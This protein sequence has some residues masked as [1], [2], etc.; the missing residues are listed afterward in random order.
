MAWTLQL[1]RAHLEAKR[2]D[3]A[4][5]VYMTTSHFSEFRAQRIAP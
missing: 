1:S 3:I 2:V 4:Y 5:V